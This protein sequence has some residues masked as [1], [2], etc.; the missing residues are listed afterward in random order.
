MTARP[1][2]CHVVGARPNYMKI[3]PVYAALEERGLVEQR[4]IHTGQHYDPLLNDVFFDQ[5][6]L[7]RPDRFLDVG[8]GTQA[9]QTAKA[10]VA[11]ERALLELAPRLVV[12]P[13]DVNSTLAAALAA[14]K[15]GMP[16]CHVESGLRSFDATMPEEL[17]RRLT[18]HLSSLLLAHSQTA[19][20]NL[21]AEGMTGE[22]VR[23]VGNT[24]IDSLFAIAPA[25][26][27]RAAARDYDL[28]PGTYVLVTLHR[29]ALVDDRAL[30]DR[31]LAALGRLARSLPVLFPAHPRTA[32]RLAE[33]GLAVP[34]GVRIVG[35]MP[36]LEFVSLELSA[37]AVATDSGGI[38]EET[39]AL[40]IRCFTL[41]DTTERPVTVTEGTN[42]VLGLEP[43]RLVEIPDR[44]HERPRSFGP[45]PLWDGHAGERA[46][47]EIE[48][49]LGLSPAR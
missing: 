31:T 7:P 44:L 39:T 43:E 32:Q 8:S 2:V 42:E 47:A 4:L 33:F 14:A 1:V 20:D 3:A 37:A 6:P 16:I 24:M 30:L 34:D 19:V 49:V 45:P 28:A 25:A 27:E 11:V 18:D 10:L 13:G 17:N 22:A 21:A 46:A 29:P 26:R 35:P 36:Y 40:G 5:L 38:Q 41:R 15:L 23:L 48:K 12:V 9:E